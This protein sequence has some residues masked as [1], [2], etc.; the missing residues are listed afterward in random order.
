MAEAVDPPFERPDA[1]FNSLEGW[2]WVGCYGGYYL[3]ADLLAAFEHGF[4]TRQWQG[5]GPGELAGYVSAGV[6]VHRPRQVHSARVLPASAAGGEPWPEA[7]G[8]VSDGGGQSL[9]V[10]GA[11][12]TPVLLADPAS[13]RVAACHVGWRGLAGGI[14]LEAIAQLV[15]AGSRREQLL[16]ALGPAVSGD[17]YQVERP[18]SVRV[19]AS[20]LAAPGAAPLQ[21]EALGP[22]KL[23]AALA[24]LSEAGALLPDPDPARDRLDIRR[25]TRLQLANAGLDPGRVA[26]CPLCTVAEPL[27]FHSWRRDQVKAVQ[28]SGIVAQAA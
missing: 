11:D 20:V 7:D 21:P 26:L 4:F 19:A 23:E 24:N 3:Q 8:L 9:W 22:E 15:A 28:W 10:C 5:R 1:G 12:C 25:A 27:L 16:V 2:T 6:S 17:N 13:G 18:V 14:L